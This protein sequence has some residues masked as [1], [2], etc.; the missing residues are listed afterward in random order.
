MA[1]LSNLG[2]PVWEC[3]SASVRPRALPRPGHR[4]T[5]NPNQPPLKPPPKLLEPSYAVVGEIIYL[6]TYMIAP[7]NKPDFRPGGASFAVLWSLRGRGGLGAKAP[8]QITKTTSASK[9][10]IAP[11]VHTSNFQA[12]LINRS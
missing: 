10:Q 9:L 11:G 5:P 12:V 6:Y 2:R 7:G 4:E 1:P 8:L 3:V